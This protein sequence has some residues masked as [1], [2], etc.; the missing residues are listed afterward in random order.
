MLVSLPNVGFNAHEV[1]NSIQNLSLSDGPKNMKDGKE[2]NYLN[3]WRIKPKNRVFQD[4]WVH[5]FPWAEL[6]IRENGL[7]F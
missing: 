2:L 4:T 1:S 7:V 3:L 6:V 5:P